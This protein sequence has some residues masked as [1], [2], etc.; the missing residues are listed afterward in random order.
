MLSVLFCVAH[1]PRVSPPSISVWSVRQ[2]VAVSSSAPKQKLRCW[3]IFLHR[4]F[5]FCFSGSDGAPIARAQSFSADT[6]TTGQRNHRP[7]VYKKQCYTVAAFTCSPGSLYS[8]CTPPAKK[9]RKRQL[10]KYAH[11]NACHS[12]FTL[13]C[14]FGMS[15][16]TFY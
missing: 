15:H 12:Y 1:S 14:N 9:G 10:H 4:F 2:T 11:S 3:R 8:L 7:C 6:N 16:Y 5:C 13:Q